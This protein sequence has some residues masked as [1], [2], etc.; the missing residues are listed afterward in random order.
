M[1]SDL[2]CRC[3]GG[4]CE[5]QRPYLIYGC[6]G[7]HL[8]NLMALVLDFYAS[9]AVELLTPARSKDNRLILAVAMLL[10]I[11]GICILPTFS[12]CPA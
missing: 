4:Q 7:S 12:F 1:P 11:S 3:G 6:D 5:N 9:C 2:Q 10:G 8:L